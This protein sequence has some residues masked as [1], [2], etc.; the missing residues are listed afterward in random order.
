M[1]DY[2]QASCYHGFGANFLSPEIGIVCMLVLAGLLKI[3]NPHK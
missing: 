2:L 3:F 1:C